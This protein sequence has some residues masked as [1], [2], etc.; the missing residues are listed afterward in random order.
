M[1][2]VGVS[3]QGVRWYLHGRLRA[4]SCDVGEFLY[5]FWGSVAIVV[6]AGC[7]RRG[8]ENGSSSWLLHALP[9]L[10]WLM[11]C[12]DGRKILGPS[13]LLCRGLPMGPLS[14]SLWPL[15]LGGVILGL[16]GVIRVYFR[17]VGVGC[18][19]DPLC[20]VEYPPLGVRLEDLDGGLL[21][22]CAEGVPWGDGSLPSGRVEVWGGHTAQELI[23]NEQPNLV[24]AS[25]QRYL[26]LVAVWW[27]CSVSVR[28]SHCHVFLG[29]LDPGQAPLKTLLLML[30]LTQVLF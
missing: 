9:R 25:L 4:V 13:T 21:G 6:R 26:V 11:V 8:G 1:A 7:R 12:Q 17:G 30:R 28:K 10:V 3:Q 29:G 27:L 20:P 24:G 19:K 23:N 15:W 18:H 5:C 16:S 2:L 14:L 22:G